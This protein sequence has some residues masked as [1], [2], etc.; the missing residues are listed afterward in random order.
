MDPVHDLRAFEGL[1]LL[2]P[3]ACRYEFGLPPRQ[4]TYTI[5]YRDDGTLT[6]AS[7]W[8]S[9]SGRNRTLQFTGPIDGKPHPIGN[10]RIADAL[11]FEF[12][13]PLRLHSSAWRDGRKVMWAER[14]L[15]PPDT[16]QIDVHGTLAQGRIYTNT[17]VYR[18]HSP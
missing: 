14:I 2:Q 16:L 3:E 10:S 13:S 12:V 15:M 1:W 4:G 18:R 5:R 11:Q 7:D 6:V 9:A 8:I 17:D